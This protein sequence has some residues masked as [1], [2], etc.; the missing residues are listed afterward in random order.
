M[1]A[2]VLSC[3][4]WNSKNGFCCRFVTTE[5]FQEYVT[6]NNLLTKFGGNDPWVFNYDTEKAA[7][8]DLYQRSVMIA[9]RDERPAGEA[10]NVIMSEEAVEDVDQSPVDV[11]EPVG[12]SRDNSKQVR[13]SSGLPPTRQSRFGPDDCG[14]DTVYGSSQ[15]PDQAKLRRGSAPNFGFRRRQVSR[16]INLQEPPQSRWL[17]RETNGELPISQ[18]SFDNATVVGGALLW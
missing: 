16:L 1:C 5:N 18:Q 11:N 6:A 3:D 12:V 7:M 15:S 13:F 4:V 2:H 14:S 9:E 8:T 17:P 10:D